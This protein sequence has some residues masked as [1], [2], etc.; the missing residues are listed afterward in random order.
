MAFSRVATRQLRGAN[1]LPLAGTVESSWAEEC[2]DAADG[3]V[4][5][6]RSPVGPSPDSP[7]GEVVV[8]RL[9]GL[10]P[11]G[12]GHEGRHYCGVMGFQHAAPPLSNP[13]DV[14]QINSANFPNR[15]LGRQS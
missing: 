13:C 8:L 15:A 9:T 7:K 11:L 6:P 14:Q 1:L 5:F 2:A 10:S 4:K 12:I 3:G